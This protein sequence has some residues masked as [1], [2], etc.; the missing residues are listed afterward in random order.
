MQGGGV[1]ILEFPV[2]TDERVSAGG[3]TLDG[4]DPGGSVFSDESV[5]ELIGD[6]PDGDPHDWEPGEEIIGAVSIIETK[7]N[8]PGRVLYVATFDF[9]DS[10][11]VVVTGF[12]PGEGTWNGRAPASAH[13]GG[14][15]REI[16]VVGWNPKG[17]G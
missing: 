6:F 11:P 2:W 4:V 9:G 1:P 12:V 5:R 13:R 14:N 7:T 10:A 3:Q 16:V 8:R 17:W 15:G